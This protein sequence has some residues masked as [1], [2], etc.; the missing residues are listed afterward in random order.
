[1]DTTTSSGMNMESSKNSNGSKPLEIYISQHEYF[2][3]L[4]FHVFF[5]GIDTNIGSNMNMDFSLN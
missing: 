3:N 2:L 4:T 5:Y 1:M